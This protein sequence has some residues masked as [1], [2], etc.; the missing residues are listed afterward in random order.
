MKT[1]L[2]LLLI[3]LLAF[4]VVACDGETQPPAEAQAFGSVGGYKAIWQQMEVLDD[5]LVGHASANQAKD[6]LTGTIGTY[7]RPV[8]YSITVL[9]DSLS[10]SILGSLTLQWSADPETGYWQDLDN[11]VINGVQMTDTYT[12]AILGGT[13]RVRA[14]DGAATGNT[15]LQVHAIIAED[16][17]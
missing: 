5:T 7:Y 12:G 1:F 2:N 14:L 3:A 17:P 15:R 11:T 8:N 10:G 9:G 4:A 6:T 16:Q 13:L